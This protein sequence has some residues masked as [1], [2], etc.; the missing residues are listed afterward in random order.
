MDIPI[1]T[2][3][4]IYELWIYQSEHYILYIIHIIYL[5]TYF[6]ILLYIFGVQRVNLINSY[7]PFGM[8]RTLLDPIG[9]E[10][11]LGLS[12]IHRMIPA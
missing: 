1:R 4:L 12:L 2:F 8:T 11:A 6:N 7:Y 9:P 10:L 5:Y 3:I